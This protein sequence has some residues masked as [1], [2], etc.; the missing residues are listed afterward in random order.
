MDWHIVVIYRKWY[1]GNVSRWN[2]EK[3][4]Y[5]LMTCSCISYFS[6]DYTHS[7][8]KTSLLYFT[9]WIGNLLCH[10]FGFGQ[11]LVY[12]SIERDEWIFFIF[13]LNQICCHLFSFGMRWDVFTMC[14]DSEQIDGLYEVINFNKLSPSAKLII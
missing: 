12:Y 4:K 6:I 10:C 14:G 2:L 7:K 3:N 9:S 5:R 1:I 8:I 11:I 13:M